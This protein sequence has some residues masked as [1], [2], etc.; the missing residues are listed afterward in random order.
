MIEIPLVVQDTALLSSPGLRL[1]QNRSFDYIKTISNRVRDVGGVLTLSWHPGYIN[2]DPY[3]DLYE[4]ILEYLSSQN[5]WLTSVGEVGR[6][7]QTKNEG[8]LKR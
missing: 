2:Q 5:A 1:N 6:W 8:L 3:F 4:Q 7:I